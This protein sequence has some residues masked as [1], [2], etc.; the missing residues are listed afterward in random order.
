MA[1]SEQTQ[2]SGKESEKTPK[3]SETDSLP[4]SEN[5]SRKKRS[6]IDSETTEC[7][8]DCNGERADNF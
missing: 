3:P 1:D 7:R 4:P 5:K 2:T 6:I 8:Y